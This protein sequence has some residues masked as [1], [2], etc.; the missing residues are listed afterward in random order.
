MVRKKIMCIS[1]YIL[2]IRFHFPPPDTDFPNSSFLSLKL[3]NII[4][5]KQPPDN[6]FPSPIFFTH[7]I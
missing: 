7:P 4:K 3:T 5:L 6:I 1:F 2:G